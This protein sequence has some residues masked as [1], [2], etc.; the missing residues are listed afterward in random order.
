MDFV[1]LMRIFWPG[2]GRPVGLTILLGIVFGIV[3]R[4]FI[5]VIVF[6]LDFV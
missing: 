5:S 3:S 4:D 1:V 6:G 2:L